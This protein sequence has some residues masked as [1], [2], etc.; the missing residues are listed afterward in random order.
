M[1]STV[2]LLHSFYPSQYGLGGLLNYSLYSKAGQCQCRV[3]WVHPLLQLRNEWILIHW[4][5]QSLR[6]LMTKEA[7]GLSPLSLE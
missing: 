4:S 1:A 2:L 3:A 5:L 7:S 6:C